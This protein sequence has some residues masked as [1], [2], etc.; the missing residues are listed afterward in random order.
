MTQQY[1]CYDSHGCIR[2]CTCRKSPS[3]DRS[4]I[5]ITKLKHAEETLL[6]HHCMDACVDIALCAL[7]LTA[8]QGVSGTQPCMTK[9]KDMTIR[10]VT[11]LV[12]PQLSNQSPL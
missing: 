8:H 12:I 1:M 3:T 7:V 11:A 6:Q 5:H 9:T 2:R 4:C 10:Q